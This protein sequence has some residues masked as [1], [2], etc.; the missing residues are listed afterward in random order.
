MRDYAQ[1]AIELLGAK[2]LGELKSDRV[3]QLR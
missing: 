1:E 2:S 3:L